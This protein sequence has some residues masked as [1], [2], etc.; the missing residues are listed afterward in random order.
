MCYPPS[1]ERCFLPVVANALDLARIYHGTDVKDISILHE[2]HRGFDAYAA[3]AEGFQVDVLL[4]SQ[5]VESGRF[6]SPC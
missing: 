6:A 3:F 2:P 5:L 4:Q 1:R